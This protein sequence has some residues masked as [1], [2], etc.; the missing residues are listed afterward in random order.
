MNYVWVKRKLKAKHLT[1]KTF[2]QFWTFDLNETSLKFHSIVSCQAVKL[3][4][5]SSVKKI[6]LF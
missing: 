6:I 3:C 5:K 1:K 2:V 4:F